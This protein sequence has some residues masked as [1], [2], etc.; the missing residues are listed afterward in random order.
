MRYGFRRKRLFNYFQLLQLNIK[1][2]NLNLISVIEKTL[3]REIRHGQ[4]HV[5]NAFQTGLL[6]W[7]FYNVVAL[8]FIAADRIQHRLFF[9]IHDFGCNFS[10]QCTSIM[11]H[12]H[13][14][15]FVFLLDFDKYRMFYKFVF[16]VLVVLGLRGPLLCKKMS[17]QL[18]CFRMIKVSKNKL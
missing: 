14:T 9:N 1:T 16:A 4:L 15:K 12:R 10:N 11:R 6:L 5:R 17:Q 7:P 2:T 18:L 3:P 13:E 8:N